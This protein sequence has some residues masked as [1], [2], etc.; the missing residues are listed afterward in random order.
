MSIPAG[1]EPVVPMPERTPVAIRAAVAR[2]DV[3]ALPRF[4][5]EWTAAT[6]LAR[7]E[8]SV[9]PVQHFT[10]KWWLW[11]A[12]RRWPDLAAQLRECERRAAAAGDLADAR[13]ASAEIGEILRAAADAA[14]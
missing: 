8:Y 13:A 2:L 3:A 4:E 11:V 7:D 10:E 6:A 12:V 9:M 14:A 1:A 5:A